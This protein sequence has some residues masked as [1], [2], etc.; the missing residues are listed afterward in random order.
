MSARELN[1]QQ[2]T[3]TWPVAIDSLQPDSLLRIVEPIAVTWTVEDDTTIAN[4]PEINEYG[5]GDTVAEA[6]EDLQA[7]IAELY[8]HLDE[9][10]DKLGP[11]LQKVYKTLTR[12]LNR[13]DAPHSA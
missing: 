11:D 2:A 4:A 7:T 10:H 3:E 6:I 9:N 13:I 5:Y 12:K 1:P 8:L